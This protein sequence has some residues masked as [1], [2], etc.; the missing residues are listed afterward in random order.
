MEQRLEEWT[1]LKMVLD[2]RHRC[3]EQ[4]LGQKARVTQEQVRQ[5]VA[6][7]FAACCQRLIGIIGCLSL[8][9]SLIATLAQKPC[10]VLSGCRSPCGWVRGR[11][12]ATANNETVHESAESGPGALR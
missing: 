6:T 2:W 5:I 4:A 1:A 10:Q 9:V 11:D 12:Q 8:Y 7:L 3:L